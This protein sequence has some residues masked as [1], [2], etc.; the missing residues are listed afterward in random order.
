M[1]KTKKVFG[2]IVAL[3]AIVSLFVAGIN[4]QSIASYADETAINSV[5]SITY[6]GAPKVEE[7]KVVNTDGTEETIDISAL[8]MVSLNDVKDKIEERET[9][10]ALEEAKADAE[11]A[12][13][14]EDVNKAIDRV[15]Q[16]FDPEGQYDRTV[17]IVTD[18]FDVKMSAD[19]EAKAKQGGV[20]VT[21]KAVADI[22]LFKSVT[23]GSQWEV[24]EIVKPNA[25]QAAAPLNAAGDQ[26]ITVLMKGS[27]TVVFESLSQ[28]AVEKFN[29]KKAETKACCECCKDCPFCSFLCKDGKCYCWTM[30]LVI[31]LAAILVILLIAL[32]VVKAKARKEVDVQDRRVEEPE[33]EI[34]EVQRPDDQGEEK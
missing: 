26:T 6:K 24:L 2:Y 14:G 22:V 17:M 15:A 8:T 13:F 31:V 30:Y 5:P 16:T 25:P 23:P 32:A 33:E 4:V 28:D 11:K 19:I 1:E 3:L 7:V 34:E 21:F 29:Q 18:V 20:K 27:G 12:D 10:E 9:K